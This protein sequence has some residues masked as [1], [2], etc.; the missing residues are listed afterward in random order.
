M[1]WRSS[2]AIGGLS[3]KGKKRERLCREKMNLDV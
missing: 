1:C 2:F 3:G